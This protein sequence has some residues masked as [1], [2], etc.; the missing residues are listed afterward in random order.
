MPD[1]ADR[2][3]GVWLAHLL[4][5]TVRRLEN[6]KSDGAF[7]AE[8]GSAALWPIACDAHKKDLKKT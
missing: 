1:G 2:F 7:A 8:V 5:E 4:D 3:L 6:D